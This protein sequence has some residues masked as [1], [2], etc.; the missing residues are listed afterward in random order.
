MSRRD[1]SVVRMDLNVDRLRKSEC[2]PYRKMFAVM[3][4]RSLLENICHKEIPGK[5]G[6]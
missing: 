1:S 3:P 2:L 6:K 4:S 5:F